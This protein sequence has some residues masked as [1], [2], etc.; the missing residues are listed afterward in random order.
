MNILIKSGLVIKYRTGKRN[1]LVFVNLP[2]ELP[3]TMRANI[4]V[5]LL[6][7]AMI[8]VLKIVLLPHMD[9]A[10]VLQVS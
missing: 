7:L 5:P 10:W 3:L 9:L 1:M 6:L 8:L 2:A 4:L